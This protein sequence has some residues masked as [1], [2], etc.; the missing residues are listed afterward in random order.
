VLNFQ[1]LAI[2]LYVIYI[3]GLHMW[4]FI[5]LLCWSLICVSVCLVHRW[6]SLRGSGS[7]SS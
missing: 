3:M 5:V 6:Q 1:I 2:I 7:D 4:Y